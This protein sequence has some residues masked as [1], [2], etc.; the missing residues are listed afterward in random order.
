[1]R[2]LAAELSE[3]SH[4]FVGFCVV[5]MVL[6]RRITW[7]CMFVLIMPYSCHNLYIE[8]KIVLCYSS[9]R[10]MEKILSLHSAVQ[11]LCDKSEDLELNESFFIDK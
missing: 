3:S 5:K 9:Y 4:L 8:I 1:M 2:A 11:E 6:D 10:K 7:L